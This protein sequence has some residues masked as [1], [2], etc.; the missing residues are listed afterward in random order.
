EFMGGEMGFNSSPNV[1]SIFFFS[2]PLP[3]QGEGAA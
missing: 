3:G 1:G 2:L